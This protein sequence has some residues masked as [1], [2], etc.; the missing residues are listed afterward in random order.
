MRIMV[1]AQSQYENPTNRSVLEGLAG[2]Y[3]RR[4]NSVIAAGAGP[5]GKKFRHR[6]PAPWG[7]IRLLGE[8]K[9]NVFER[10]T[11]TYLQLSSILHR[12]DF[13]HIQFTGYWDLPLFA[14]CSAAAQASIRV[15]VTF[16]DYRN[17]VYRAPNRGELAALGTVLPRFEWTTAV[18][19]DIA[20]VIGRDIPTL[21]RRLRVV[22]NG[23]EAREA[24]AR[25]S[26]RPS[27][28]N[29]PFVLCVARLSM[30]KGIDVLLMAWKDVC[31]KTKDVE[32]LLCGVD[33]EDGHY[34]N[35]ARV[36]GVADR[37]RFMG[38]V[39]PARVWSLLRAAR[40]FVL[41][42]RH[43]SFGMAALE[44]MACGK[45]VVASR[46]G[47]LAE[48]VTD[49]NSGILVPPRDIASLREALL[50]LLGDAALRR[51]L[52]AAARRDAQE[53][54]WDRVADRYLKIVG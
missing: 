36:L 2:A 28:P 33:H 30:Y 4:G 11:T 9:E 15:G 47:G 8:G 40:V 34:Q 32:L 29:R 13:L 27:A 19:R 16:Q 21:R 52:G 51:R 3:H 22:P 48:F 23:F 38:Q 1:L 50:K 10:A 18:S 5:L 53:Y 20:R 44:A 7:E 12:I 43:E 37:V 42:S 46:C 35:L 25:A 26:K 41:P 39:E 24:S 49:R 31:E 54:T 6:R 45:P 17:P 14:I